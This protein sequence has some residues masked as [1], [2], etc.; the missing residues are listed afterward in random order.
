LLGW[1]K[2]GKLKPHISKTYP[3]AQAAQALNDVLERRVMG[4][5]VVTME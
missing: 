2:E 3:L 5:V 4:K 1:F